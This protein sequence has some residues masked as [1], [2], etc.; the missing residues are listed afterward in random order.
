LLVAFQ[1]WKSRCAITSKRFGGHY[2]L[3]L[4]RWHPD[5]PPTPYN[6]VLMM[7][8]DAD[9]LATLGKEQAFSQELIE[10]IEKRLEWAKSVYC[11]EDQFD[12]FIMKQISRRHLPA[13]QVNSTGISKM[14]SVI[15]TNLL[16]GLGCI[17]G[18]LVLRSFLVKR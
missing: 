7:Q 6:L 4:T 12:E 8:S 16:L 3:T 10:K 11:S 15:S 2:I 1:V 5:L 17:C 18:L 14:P 9:K 13:S